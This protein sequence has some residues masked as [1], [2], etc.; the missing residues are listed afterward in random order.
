MDSR[1]WDNVILVLKSQNGKLLTSS[2]CTTQNSSLQQNKGRLTCKYKQ[3]K[4]M[5][6]EE[7]QMESDNNPQEQS[8]PQ[9]EAPL[10]ADSG[11]EEEVE[12]SEGED[13]ESSADEEQYFEYWG[14]K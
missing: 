10:E 13:E 2:D 9:E 6:E 7:Q 5:S 12:V 1:Q 3:T 4:S 8:V 14:Y 11:T